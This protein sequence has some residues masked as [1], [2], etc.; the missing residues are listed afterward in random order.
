MKNLTQAL[1]KKLF[2]KLFQRPDFLGIYGDYDGVLTFL[3]KI[4]PL[5][6]MPSEDSRF[7]NAMDDARQHLVNNSDWELDYTF[8]ERF[9]LIDG[10]DEIFNAF[11]EVAVSPDV[12]KTKESIQEYVNL[13]NYQLARS[14]Y[15]M[16]HVDYFE[17][18]PV[19][20][21]MDKGQFS[22]LP[23]EISANQVPFFKG[24]D[25]IDHHPCF[26]LFQSDWDDYGHETTF[27]LQYRKSASSFERIGQ[28]NI[29][30][31]GVK[32]TWDVVPDR[33]TQLEDDFCS[34]GSGIHFYEAFRD[35]FGPNYQSALYA[36]RDV[37]LFPRIADEFEDDDIF[38]TSLLRMNETESLMRTARF[39]L[40]GIDLTQAFKFNFTT[41]PP[42]A[43]NDILLNFDFQ[44]AEKIKHRIYGLI[45]KN[46]TGKTRILSSLIHALSEEN[47]AA[48]TPKKPLYGKIFSVSYSFFDRFEPPEANASFNYVYCGLKKRGGGWLTEDELTARFFES[49][50]RIKRKRLMV[51][52]NEILKTFIPADILS[53][54]FGRIDGHFAFIAE[55]FSSVYGKV[56]SGQNIL[57]FI[58][59]EII[60]QIRQNSLII[61]DEPETHLH[62]NAISELMNTLFTMTENFNSFCIIATHSPIV[63]QELQSRNVYVIEREEASV[64]ARKL[65][66]E[67]F[68]ENLTVITED[69]FG[70]RDVSKHYIQFLRRLVNENMTFEEI[71]GTIE[72]NDLPLSLNARLYIKSLISEYNENA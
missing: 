21:L 69:I 27:V 31:S 26:V 16:V 65:D 61:Y 72:T 32:K 67:V 39:K 53:E 24:A 29:M 5:Q 13:I 37:A 64:S 12:R 58:I 28:F 45:G 15:R 38:R 49:A 19:Y 23:L 51:E 4:W 56:S 10:P 54:M 40:N 44:Y 6:D 50:E 68:A 11:L 17:E 1:K 35:I 30:K 52:W 2:Q 7:S 22:D 20:K 36:L 46:G 63:I 14:G 3:A 66:K 48:I 62:P 41:R 59:T 34:L 57:L 25:N 55:K 33:F 60:A 42:Y 18:L 47:P 9:N 71:V 70:N 43:E 8:T